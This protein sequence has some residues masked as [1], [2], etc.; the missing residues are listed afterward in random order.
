MSAMFNVRRVGAGDRVDDMLLG[1]S[2]NTREQ[3]EIWRRRYAER[4]PHMRF[5]VCG[6]KFNF[7]AP[8]DLERFMRVDP[9]QSEDSPCRR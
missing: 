5:E 3:A 8:R 1:M 6:T 9:A 4:Y 7:T 2:A